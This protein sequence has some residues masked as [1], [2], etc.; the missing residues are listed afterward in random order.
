MDKKILVLIIFALIAVAVFLVYREFTPSSRDSYDVSQIIDGDTIR[1]STGEKVRLIGINAPERDQP[2]YNA[3]TQKLTELIGNNQVTLEK[4][5][6]D[7]DQYGR[8]LRYVHVND[9]FMN[10]EMVK[11]GYAISYSFPPNTKH[12]D[13]FV[14]VEEDARNSQIGIWTPSPFTLTVSS[15]HADAE[16]D[17]S[18][19]L[20]D[21]YIIFENVGDS[22]LNMTY[23]TVQDE[24]NNFYV[25]STFF[26]GNNY[27]VTL[28]TGSGT[29][30]ST[31]VYWES[32]KPIWNNDG[33]SLYLRDAEGLL[34]TYYSY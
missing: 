6:T 19:N 29:D 12:L 21:E 24:A 4:D 7:K 28:Y 2:Y 8:L 14:E 5:V 10:L 13:E 15:I 17:D 22:T 25:F 1:L 26:L 20:N 9:A 23:W 30:T 16:G 33:D 32:S 11:Q 34:V 18:E 3:A 27:S 31:K